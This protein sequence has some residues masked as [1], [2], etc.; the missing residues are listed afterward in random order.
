MEFKDYYK[1]LG[2]DKSANKD[3]IK[4]AY[5]KL[6]RKYHP[7]VSKEQNAEEKFKEAKE[8]YEVLSDPEKHKAYDNL[9]A[10]W[11]HG[12]DF[13]PPPD[14]GQ[15]GGGGFYTSGF[16]QAGAEDFSDFFSELFGQRGFQT[17]KRSR[18]GFQTKGQ[19]ARVKVLINL[20]DAYHGATKQINLQVPEVDQ[21]GR[22]INKTKSLK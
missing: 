10:N 12:Q 19:D 1:I 17:G 8:A 3:E 13:T 22:L 15:A 21:H 6:A 14:W 5:R 9:G 2:I 11:R 7:D 16:T 20:E 18:Q 4:R